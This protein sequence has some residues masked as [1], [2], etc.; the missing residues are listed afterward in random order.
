M[1]QNKSDIGDEPIYIAEYIKSNYPT[2][3]R[4]DKRDFYLY[5]ESEG[6][7]KILDP[8]E[9]W[10]IKTIIYKTLLSLRKLKK[11]K[12]SIINDVLFCLQLDTEIYKP[13]MNNYDNYIAMNNGVF[14]YEKGIIMP[15]SKDIYISNKIRVNFNKEKDC[16]HFIEYLRHTFNDNE[17]VITNIQMLGGYLLS[18]S[19]EVMRQVNSM[20]VFLG[21]GGAGK[22]VLLDEVLRRLFIDDPTIVTSMSLTDITS[23]GSSTMRTHLA[24]SRWNFCTEADSNTYIKNDGELK[25][26]ISGEPTQINV[27]YKSPC[28]VR[29][30][31]KML[32]STNYLFKTRDKGWSMNRRI[33]IFR[34]NNQYLPEER[35]KK[36]LEQYGTE[37]ELN[38]RN[39]Y[40]KNPGLSEKLIEELDGIFNYFYLGWLMFKENNYQFK[41][42]EYFNDETSSDKVS[43]SDLMKQEDP[44]FLFINDYCEFV[45]IGQYIS[46]TQAEELYD[47]YKKWY[48]ELWSG[49]QNICNYSVFSRR[50][51]SMFED[52]IDKNRITVNGKKRTTYNIKI[53]DFGNDER[54]AININDTELKGY[55]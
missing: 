20:F 19:Y 7:Y 16:P 26:I 23:G 2:L 54:N 10:G 43:G 42:V 27:K 39:I 14:D 41:N 18:P 28:S 30:K 36:K 40:R 6:I 45:P 11:I 22:S 13:E 1:M 9:Y 53:L 50:I 8:I 34:F 12:S 37:D 21:P 48:K 29:P 51:Q 24:T 46:Y 4:D 17:D 55:L 15:Y 47:E 35:Y 49:Q 3:I 25:K 52:Q 32:M 38:K 31:M 33:K 44:E 5:D